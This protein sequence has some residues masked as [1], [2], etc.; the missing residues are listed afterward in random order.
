M[1]F[2]RI[3]ILILLVASSAALA[4]AYRW[5]DEDGVV[6]YSDRP[7]PG[8]EA[9]ELP[10][11]NTTTVRVPSRVNRRGPG[12][13]DSSSTPDFEYQSLS[14]SAPASEEVLWN[15]GAV[16]DVSLSV[17]PKMRPGHRLRVYFDG[18]PQE[19]TSLRFR[20][21]EVYRGEHNLQAEIVDSDGK[22]MIR[23][24][25]VRFYVQQSSIAS[26]G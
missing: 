8:G 6:H 20:L 17:N 7:M 12:D 26:P 23:S 22:L 4:Q 16:L 9:V 15:I 2:R 14:I 10:K 19:V 24:E 3:S 5:V 18:V 11:S 13:E 25:T 1:D 21:N